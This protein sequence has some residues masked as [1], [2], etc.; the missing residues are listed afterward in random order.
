MTGTVA[1]AVAQANQELY[2]AFESADLDRMSALWVDAPWA[3]TATCV[4]PGWPPV[5][6]RGAVLRSWAVIMANTAYIQFVLTDVAVEVAGEVAVV[7]CTENLLTGVDERL[8]GGRVVATN[9]FRRTPVG[10][11]LWVH[12]GS[13]VLA[14][15]GEGAGPTG[16]GPG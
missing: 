3:D 9:V 10:W 7:T 15:Q 6:G 8:G 4:H 2:A 12:H 5:R 16:G 14:P 11:R 1:A 13:P